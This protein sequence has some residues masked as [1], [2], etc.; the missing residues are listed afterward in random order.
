MGRGPGFAAAAAQARPAWQHGHTRTSVRGEGWAGGKSWG[1]GL[2]KLL[3]L[4]AACLPC[5]S[6]VIQDVG[7]PAQPLSP[8]PCYRCGKC[9]A[10]VS[11]KA[12]LAGCVRAARL[13]QGTCLGA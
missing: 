9:C 5:W 4:S 2:A 8:R 10:R 7:A 13:L 12:G 1:E 3:R 11:G 6:T